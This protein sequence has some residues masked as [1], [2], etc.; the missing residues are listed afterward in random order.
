MPS[1]WNLEQPARR[2]WIS[3]S[4]SNG[5]THKKLMY[6]YDTYDS[7]NGPS[8]KGSFLNLSK[9]HRHSSTTIKL[10]SSQSLFQLYLEHF[11]SGSPNPAKLPASWGSPC[12]VAA[13]RTSLRKNSTF[14]L[15]S[16]SDK[17]NTSGN[18]IEK[19]NFT[20]FKLQLLIWT[21]IQ[22]K[23]FF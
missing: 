20:F 6:W 14:A 15:A 11:H 19:D 12:H 3:R 8:G 7:S 2:G 9:I 5:K 22:P 4:K 17:M 18:F 10:N 16:T 23:G 13:M 1:F 21:S